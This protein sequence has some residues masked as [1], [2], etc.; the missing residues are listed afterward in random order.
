MNYAYKMW[1]HQ[2]RGG[3][4]WD[5]LTYLWKLAFSYEAAALPSVHSDGEAVP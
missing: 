4:C 2:E 1:Y 3:G 5:V